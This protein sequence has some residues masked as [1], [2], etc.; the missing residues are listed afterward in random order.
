VVI[1]Y[2]FLSI[3]GIVIEMMGYLIMVSFN[4]LWKS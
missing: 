2:G 3:G 4:T 1:D